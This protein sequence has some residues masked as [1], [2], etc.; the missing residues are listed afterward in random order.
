MQKI[1]VILTGG[2]I[3]SS[4]NKDYISIGSGE[5]KYKIIELFK[6]KYPDISCETEFDTCEPYMIL[7][8]NL[9]GAYLNKLTDCVRDNLGKGYDGIIVTHGTDTLQYSA[10]ALGLSVSNPDIP[11]ILVSSNYVLDDER[12]NG[13]DN[14]ANAVK[15]I[16]DKCTPGVFVSYDRI[17]H[18]SLLL[19]S[20]TAYSD[21]LYS[22]S[23]SK[24]SNSENETDKIPYDTIR[25]SDNSPIMYIK[26]VPG[27]AYPSLD[28]PD[29]KAVLLE[30]YHSGTLCTDSQKFKD[31]CESAYKLNKRIY[32]TGIEDRTQYESTSLY[33]SLHLTILKSDSPIT[34]YMKL[35]F[36]Y[37][38]GA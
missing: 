22:L 37:S 9:D 32:V 5:N 14:F 1:L 23:S 8:E 7:S 20:H 3:A 17:I 29:I 13:L 16:S 21:K 24:K 35:W 36:L 4:A 12:S 25:L 33:E 18:N 27:Q 38:K 30:T 10:A 19:L 26:A 6:N 11:V 28:N 31:F 2:T 15:Y 34:A